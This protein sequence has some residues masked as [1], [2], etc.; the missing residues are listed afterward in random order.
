M[1]AM[2]RW[3]LKRNENSEVIIIA[4]SISEENIEYMMMESCNLIIL[5]KIYNGQVIQNRMAQK[6][7]NP[8]C[9]SIWTTVKFRSEKSSQ[10]FIEA[11]KRFL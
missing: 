1:A 2:V 5:A 8:Q 3:K 11:V 9:T 6:E 7:I 4:E 10:K